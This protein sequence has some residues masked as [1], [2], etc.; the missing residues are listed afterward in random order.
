MNVFTIDAGNT[1]IKAALFSDNILI[2]FQEKLSEVEAIKFV[3]RYPDARIIIST[4]SR[5]MYNFKNLLVNPS[6]MF[7]LSHLTPTPIKNYYQ[8]PETLGMDR[9]AAACGAWKLNHGKSS[10]CIDMGTCITY[11]VINSD[12]EYHGGS[13]SPGMNMRFEALAHYTAKLPKVSSDG[14]IPFIG[15]DTLSAIRSGVVNGI[16]AE[17]EGII[18]LYQEKVGID[19]IYLCGGDATFFTSKTSK[20]VEIVPELVLIGL[21]TIVDHNENRI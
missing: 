20:T 9:L 16:I 5:E 21:N 15:Y 2:E 8:S 10:L 17:V 13:I 6:R 12:G 4:V 7:V 14:D 19:T 3:N 1:F 11:D 18:S